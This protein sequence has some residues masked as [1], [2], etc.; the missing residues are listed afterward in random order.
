MKTFD[1][2]QE[3]LRER[4]QPSHVVK[5]G[6]KG[7]VMNWEKVVAELVFDGYRFGLR[8]F[9]NDLDRRVVLAGA[10]RHLGG[11]VPENMRARVEATDEKF[12]NATWAASRCLLDDDAVAA[13][14]LSRELDWYFYRVPRRYLGN[15]ARD[16]QQAGIAARENE[17]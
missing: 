6:L 3:Y 5:M 11:A 16:L 8:D 9:I 4:G 13:R 17:R 14:G 1:P 2:V 7:L 10:L 15:F 12:R